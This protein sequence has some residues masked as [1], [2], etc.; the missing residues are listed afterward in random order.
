MII[1]FL[2]LV[3]VALITLIII[4]IVRSNKAKE[5]RQKYIMAAGNIFKED[6]LNYTLQNP[7]DNNE[8]Y[9]KPQDQK[10]M[11]YIKS[12]NKNNRQQYVFDPNKK[13][14]FGRDQQECNLL[15]NEA[16]VSKKHCCIFSKGF[17]VF[18][19]DLNSSNGTVVHKGLFNNLLIDNGSMVKLESGDEIIIGSNKF[20]IILFYYDVTVM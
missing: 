18:L 16:S 9:L 19:A 1:L 10:T 6:Y 7:F 2:V 5:E 11:V 17:D 13:I 4:A 12:M 20:K 8:I 3:S 14:I 15:I